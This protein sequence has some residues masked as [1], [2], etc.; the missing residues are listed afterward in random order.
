[1]ELEA[2]GQ[3]FLSHQLLP[4][5]I[6]PQDKPYTLVVEP[7]YFREEQIGFIVFEVG[8]RDGVIY[9]TLRLDISSALK[10]ALLMQRIQD[11]SA[12]LAREQYI[13]DTF[14]ANVPDR[15]YFKDLQGR[16]T[17]ANAAHA[18][19]LGFRDPA[20]E[21]GKTDFDFFPQE[22]ARLRHEQEQDIIR[23]GQ[24]V[25]NQEEQQSFPDREW[26]NWSLATKMPLRNERGEIIGTFGI[27]KDITD[28]KLA[29][30]QLVQS[31]KMA[32]LGELV[33]GVAHEINT[34]LGVGVTAAS[35]LDES[36]RA[37][38]Q[39][40]SD[41]TITRTE[42]KKYLQVAREASDI[43]LRNL[44]RASDH[45]KGFKQVA[46]DQAH[47]EKRRFTL[48][49]YLD[50]VLKSLHP[51]IKNSGHQVTVLCPPNL[52]LY[53]Y[54]GV[55][56]QI[57]SN[58]VMNSLIHGFEQTPHGEIRIEVT[59]DE[60][61]VV[62]WYQDNGK[63]MDQDTRDRIFDPFFT[64]KRGQGGSGLGMHIVYNLVTQQLSGQ[65]TCESSPNN[66]VVFVLR[67]SKGLAS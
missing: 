61:H 29:Q 59:E 43:I 36:T 19:W 39:H 37:I 2:G 62:L 23:T 13:L 35:H 45:I 5:E 40:L 4:D 8:P 38:E 48:K 26:V 9:E 7:L 65:I 31:E 18:D 46:V 30:K 41:N 1:M 11:H 60:D 52:E 16:I 10:G 12:Q 25:V 66:G 15:I 53:S 63:G 20:E 57:I 14:M 21:I 58:F 42:L 17:R 64:T 47:E 28:L 44:Q 24:S 22:E 34:P 54:P 51:K 67:I 3:R 55:F 32:A 33:A 50:D 27:S 49:P 6:L 56:S